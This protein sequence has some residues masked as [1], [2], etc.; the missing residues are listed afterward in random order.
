MSQ[1]KEEKMSLFKR[2][3]EYC[4]KKIDKG[5]EVFRNVKDPVFV[6]TKEKS[7]CC[8]SHADK[9]EEEVK[10]AKKCKSSCCG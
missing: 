2:K 7:F 8:E 1:A 10:N 6:G 3:C 5:N 4:K 9:Y